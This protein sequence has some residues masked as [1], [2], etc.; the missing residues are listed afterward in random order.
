MAKSMKSLIQE[1]ETVDLDS[2]ND[3]KTETEA[4]AMTFDFS[5]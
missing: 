4:L 2:N 5:K 1:E 3:D